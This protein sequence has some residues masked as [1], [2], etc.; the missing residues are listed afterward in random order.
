MIHLNCADV[1][2]AIK[3]HMLARFHD[4]RVLCDAVQRQQFVGGSSALAERL[5]E[6]GVLEEWSIGAEII[7][8]GAADRDL[9]LILLGQVSVVING[10]EIAF[11]TAGQHVGEMSLIDPSALRSAT[12]IAREQSVTLRISEADFTRLA[13]AHPDAWRRFAS[14]IGD[15]LRQRTRFIRTRNDTPIVFIGSSTETRAILDAITA[16]LR[17]DP[18]I[19]RPWSAAGVF[20][21]S[22]FPIDDLK[23]Q[24][25]ESD[26]AVLVIGP[27]DKVTSRGRRY[28]APRDNI[29]FELG[30]FMGALGKERVFIAH[31]RARTIKIPS[32]LLG[33]GT[34][35]FAAGPR[36][37][38]TVNKLLGR[39][40]TPGPLA[41]RIVEACDIIRD[42]VRELGAR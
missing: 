6:V 41:V 1:P 17:H 2:Q 10:R 28:L 5:T 33:L 9:F 19:V 7:S 40:T 15:R 12:V 29:V 38:E 35:R 23:R 20:G 13:A 18:F 39:T 24:L 11:R 4:K 32:D 27:D 21:A 36:R 37:L 14:E 25:D 34:I 30:L 16:E 26:F 3:I 42:K 22:H 8:Q 31:E